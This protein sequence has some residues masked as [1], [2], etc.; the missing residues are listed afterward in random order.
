MSVLAMNVEDVTVGH[1]HKGVKCEPVLEKVEV[2]ECNGNGS[3]T[4]DNAVVSIGD[5]YEGVTTA[6]PDAYP[7]ALLE[8]ACTDNS[9]LMVRTLLK[10]VMSVDINALSPK[11]GQT[12]LMVV[13]ARGYFEIMNILLSHTNI[14]IDKTDAQGSTAL[15]RAVRADRASSILLLLH[16]GA[17]LDATDNLGSTVAH[18]ATFHSEDS[19]LLRIL[20]H[21]G[22]D[23]RGE[24]NNGF[25]PLHMAVLAN[26]YDACRYLT[27]PP[28]K[29]SPFAKG[30]GSASNPAM[31]AYDVLEWTH[32]TSK[33]FN[34]LFDRSKET[35]SSFLRESYR[36]FRKR[37]IY[38]MASVIVVLLVVTVW[39]LHIHPAVLQLTLSV[40]S[41]LLQYLI[42]VLSINCIS[43]VTVCDLTLSSVVLMYVALLNL[44]P[45]FVQKR[46]RPESA[47]EDVQHTLADPLRSDD[48][49]RTA[50]GFMDICTTCG[51]VRPPHTIHCWRLDITNVLRLDHTQF[52][53]CGATCCRFWFTT[54]CG[55]G[56]LED[57]SRSCP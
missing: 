17:S 5:R 19:S 21:F 28:L 56:I 35:S 18:F 45:G 3:A 6:T 11:N 47:L 1:G 40:D 7:G 10:S 16:Y 13:A 22:A 57:S 48:E 26:N 14:Q 51:V 20:Q 53:Y 9:P 25:T 42:E 33:V 27:G 2:I 34:E 36:K 24:D 50:L 46:V 38:R 30:K 15:M 44:N 31:S 8:W 52:F 23:V 55:V 32:N 41:P 54:F 49:I 12:P 43:I 39:A 4:A 37:E 29:C